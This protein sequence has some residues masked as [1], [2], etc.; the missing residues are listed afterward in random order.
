MVE[1]LIFFN[2]GFQFYTSHGLSSMIDEEQAH[3]T[4]DLVTS[5][6]YYI[7]FIIIVTYFIV[8]VIFTIS[9]YI[10]IFIVKIFYIYVIEYNLVLT[11]VFPLP[12]FSTYPFFCL[13]LFH[14]KFFDLIHHLL[15]SIPGHLFFLPL[16]K[17]SCSLL[18]EVY[19]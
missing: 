9:C 19:M 6:L 2:Y 18:F 1:L 12:Y 8:F 14:F 17:G 10:I 7:T 13:V 4:S 15:T 11:I 5:C 16:R 3:F